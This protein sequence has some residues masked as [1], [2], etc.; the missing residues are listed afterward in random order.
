MMPRGDHFILRL[1]GGDTM[2]KWA[3]LP[4]LSW[5]N[6][7]KRLGDQAQVLAAANPG[8]TNEIPLL[9]AGRYGNGRVLAFAG[10]STYRWV[11]YGHADDH[12]RFWRQTMLWLAQKESDGEKKVM[13]RLAQ[14]RYRPASRVP[15]TVAATDELG[16]AIVD[17][18]FEV[19]LAG[20]GGYA[21]RVRVSREADDQ[22]T[23]LS[24]E[25]TAAGE[26]EYSVVA[27]RNGEE[28]G[29]A[30]G[31]FQILDQD[32]ELTDAAANPGQL[33]SMAAAT[34]EF[35]GRLLAPE[36]LPL[37][38][39]QLADQ[40][41]TAEVAYESKWQLADSNS[42]AGGLFILII[43]LLFAEWFFRKQWG[44]V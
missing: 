13:L 18:E 24:D 15:V 17:A 31:G 22:F 6:R 39:E 40:E 42:D 12:R 26:Y 34:A 14:R 25:L 7:F 44:L 30:T 19:R 1:A 37:V 27:T 9:I 16:D 43:A 33:A 4:P 35:G 29:K 2:A 38:L 20:P 21:N 8:A 3:A 36:E 28:L 11:R 10:D 5:A 32:L 23:G 41:I